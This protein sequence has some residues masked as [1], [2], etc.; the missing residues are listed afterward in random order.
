V[1][2]SYG[3]AF[4]PVTEKLW[5]TENAPNAFDE[6]NM[7]DPGF[8]SGWE[9]IMGPNNRDPQGLDD[10]FVV[11]GSRYSDPEF[12]WLETV[13]PTAL[14]FLSSGELGSRYA[15]DLFVGDIN[16]GTLYHFPLNAARDGFTFQGAGLADRVADNA[17]ELSEVIFGTDFGGITDFKVGPDGLLYVVSFR[18]S[19]Y[20][21]SRDETVEE[22]IIDNAPAGQSGNR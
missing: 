8:N 1:R 22:I 15:N 18:G 11:P 14:V 3:L 17:T 6:I 13:G 2:N 7:V 5:M 16:N 12:S 20:V 19:I 9:R 10:L 21:I 4:D